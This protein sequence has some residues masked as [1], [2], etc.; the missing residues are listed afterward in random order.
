MDIHPLSDS[1]CVLHS[2]QTRSSQNTLASTVETPEIASDRKPSDSS[3]AR[4][5][6][7]SAQK[8]TS[9]NAYARES[10]ARPATPFD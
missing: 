8:Q 9:F 5:G 6:N 7:L 10:T 4:S 2:P 1:L 3:Q